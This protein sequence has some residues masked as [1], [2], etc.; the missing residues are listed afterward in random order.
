[1]LDYPY[2]TLTGDPT[3]LTEA[4]RLRDALLSTS[5][6]QL[7]LAAGFRGA[8]GRSGSALAAAA[9][10]R[11][12]A[13]GV[14]PAP[15]PADVATAVRVTQ[16]TG[17]ASRLLAVVDVS[18]SMATPVPGAHG[19]SRLDL[20]VDAA[21]KGLALYGDDSD[22]GLWEFS[23]NLDGP[24]DYRQLA[25]ITPLGT[26]AAGRPGRLALLGALNQVA[27]SQGDTGLYDTIL[28][29]YRTVRQGY[30][31]SRYDSVVVL[32]DGQNDDKDG[33]SLTALLATLRA[34]NDPAHPLPVITLGFGESD[35]ATLSAISAATGGDSYH[36]DDPRDIASVFLD[37][38]GRR[39]CRPQC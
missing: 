39:G 31:P 30:D 24:R 25:P 14:G 20:V 6:Q 5:G 19:A 34:E 26:D 38:I 37:A 28:A 12:G 1:V 15:S 35:Q 3:R 2:L 4:R 18:G 27:V 32:T 22:I 21:S 10:V 11:A 36:V 16:L 7:L 17:R 23:T 8:D 33:L 29:A 9:G 13:P